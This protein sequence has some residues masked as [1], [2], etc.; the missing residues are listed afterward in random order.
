[1]GK[2]DA[3]TGGA[4]CRFSKED[5]R[6]AFSFLGDD[7]IPTLCSYVESREWPAD[8]VVMQDGDPGDYIGFLVK[9]R[10]A[11]KVQTSFPGRFA[12]VAILESG[13]ILGEVAAIEATRRTATVVTLEPC[14]IL[15]LTRSAMDTMLAE[16]PALGINILKRII[17]VLS[18]RLKTASTRLAKIL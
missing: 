17:H 16:N 1:M 13:S 8:Y 4:G 6:A 11:V 5:L 3:V 14:R 7:E 10:M 15:F 18:R 12:L 9:G 2:E